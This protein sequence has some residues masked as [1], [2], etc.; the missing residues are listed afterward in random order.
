MPLP[1]R[2][3]HPKRLLT[4]RT[5]V[6]RATRAAIYAMPLS[7]LLLITLTP[8]RAL[9]SAAPAAPDFVWCDGC[10][11]PGGPALTGKRFKCLICPNTDMC[12]ECF[13]SGKLP[14]GHAAE[15]EVLVFPSPAPKVLMSGAFEGLTCV[16]CNRAGFS[17]A[18]YTCNTCP[19]A[20]AA[21]AVWCEACEV[22]QKHDISH[23]RCK[24]IPPNKTPGN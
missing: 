20:G 6:S 17:G 1:L 12:A 4:V 16:F 22:Q 15:H 7:T 5:A 11:R 3:P 8:A 10:S 18:A 2:P 23:S 13:A 14:E 19:P 24:R 9:S 21:P